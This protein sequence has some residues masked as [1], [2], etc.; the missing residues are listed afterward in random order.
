[1]YSVVLW[2][3]VWPKTVNLGRSST[4]TTMAALLRFLKIRDNVRCY[5]LC[6]NFFMMWTLIDHMKHCKPS[7]TSSLNPH[8]K[9]P[10]TFDEY[11]TCL[12]GYP[13]AHG[14]RKLKQTMA[15]DD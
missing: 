13:Q 4:S 2:G 5:F 8:F 9:W 6:H 3:F 1:M 7:F 12:I 14:Q 11:M 15:S 10:S